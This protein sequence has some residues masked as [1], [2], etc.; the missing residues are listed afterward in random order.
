MANLDLPLHN[1][2][3]YNTLLNIYIY[4]KI[5]NVK[6][7]VGGYKYCSFNSVGTLHFNLVERETEVTSQMGTKEIQK[8][9]Q[10]S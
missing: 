10:G 4:V 1:V 9:Q 5:P 8:V 7:A 3:K 2:T 6:N